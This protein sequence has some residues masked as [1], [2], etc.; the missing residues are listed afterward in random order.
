MKRVHCIVEG[1]TEVRVFSMLLAPYI[2]EKTGACILFTPIKHTGGGIVKFSKIFPELRNHLK[3]KNKIVTTFF[4]YYGIYPKY[5]FKYYDEAKVQQTNAKVGAKLLEKGMKEY[6]DE[7]GVNTR[8]FIPYIQLHEFEALLFSSQ[9]GFDFQYDNERI[10]DDL[11]KVSHRYPNPEDINDSP[12]TAPSK[13]IIS[14]LE[15]HGE[16]YV[17]TSDG[18]DIATII[19][20]DTILEQCPRFRNWVETLV[21]KINELPDELI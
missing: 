8:L 3:D 2:F 5:E 21:L 9:D 15:K 14:I 1:Q 13:R 7:K 12:K 19:G 18:E 17:K 16:K 4:D 20:I 11:Q 6:L 10:L